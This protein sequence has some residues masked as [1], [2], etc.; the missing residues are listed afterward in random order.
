ME[1]K[2]QK[3]LKRL[4]TDSKKTD[5]RSDDDLTWWIYPPPAGKHRS[6][7][8][9]NEVFFRSKTAK[10]DGRRGTVVEPKPDVDDHVWVLFASSQSTNP[11]YVSCK[12]LVP[13]FS[14][15]ATDNNEKHKR[16]VVILT[17]ETIP[18]RHLAC[19]QISNTDDILEIGCSTGE[20]SSILLQY[21]RSLV[22]VDTSSEMVERCKTH[23][24]SWVEK[25]GDNVKSKEWCAMKMDPLSDPNRTVELAKKFS[26]PKGPTAVFLDI[27]G[28]RQGVA[29]T[30]VMKW[31]FDSF[32]SLRLLVV[33]SREMVKDIT[34]SN[35]NRQ[36]FV[37]DASCG[38]FQDGSVWFQ[39]QLEN[40]GG[41][42]IPCHPL[43]APL[44]HSPIDPTRPI[45]RYHNYHPKG[46][47][48]GS[49]CPYDHDHCHL[50][51]EKGHT[52]LTLD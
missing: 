33:K 23:I 22:A 27:G 16:I 47:R 51:R 52:A 12:R 9:G 34:L 32:S 4:K 3:P 5:S 24:Q 18:Y 31:V 19:S 14:A 40:H 30:E 6:F 2:T 35:T 20:T 29:V 46:C 41:R 13:V 8:T 1:H 21:G 49:N 36:G 39:R 38:L 11:S 25:K 37:A 50:C 43:Q 48:Q 42:R 15:H 44:V 45:C 10:E 7:S 17:P 28:N 26:Q